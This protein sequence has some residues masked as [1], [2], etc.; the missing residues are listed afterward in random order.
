L[1]FCLC[2]YNRGSFRELLGGFCD[3]NLSGYHQHDVNVP[4]RH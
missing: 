1:R 3:S 2:G 4:S